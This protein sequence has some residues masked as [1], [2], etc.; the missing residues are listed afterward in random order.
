[1]PRTPSRYSAAGMRSETSTPP[2]SLKYSMMPPRES[3]AI[4]RSKTF[5]TARFIRRSMRSPSRLSSPAYSSSILPA[6]DAMI[7]CR[8][9]IR[10]TISLSPHRIARFSALEMMLS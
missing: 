9:V 5:R 1:M 10:G 2:P 4:A 8:S 7:A 6:V 3:S